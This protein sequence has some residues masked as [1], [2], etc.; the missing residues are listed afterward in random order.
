[1][2]FIQFKNFIRILLIQI[3]QNFKI[4]FKFVL[5]EIKLINKPKFNIEKW[6]RELFL[7]H[8]NLN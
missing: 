1:M 6:D 2:N 5:K 3:K 7:Y 8:G 4:S